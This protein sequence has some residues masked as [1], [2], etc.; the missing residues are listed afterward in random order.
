MS[1]RAACRLDRLGFAEVYDYAPGKVDW[2]AHNLP[3]H[4]TLADAPTAGTRLRTDAV[5][6]SPEEPIGVVQA[7]IEASRYGFALVLAED[8]TLLGRLRKSA[9]DGDPK[10][11]AEQVMEPGPVTIRPHEPLDRVAARLREHKLTTGLVTDPEGHF[12]GLVHHD[13]LPIS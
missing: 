8:R 12:L 6:A 9:L 13:D 7:R 3:T 2:L 1:P 4:G 11:A 5:T 10:A